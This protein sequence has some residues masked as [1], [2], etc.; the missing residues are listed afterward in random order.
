MNIRHSRCGSL[1]RRLQWWRLALSGV[2]APPPRRWRSG[3]W[4]TLSGQQAAGA[5]V[6]DAAVGRRS[7]Q[8]T[9]P[10][11]PS[12]GLPAT[13]QAELARYQSTSTASACRPH[14]TQSP[15]HI[16]LNAQRLTRFSPTARQPRSPPAAVS[17][18]CLAKQYSPAAGSRSTMRS[19]VRH[20]ASPPSLLTAAAPAASPA[21]ATTGPVSGSPFSLSTRLFNRAAHR[22]ASLLQRPFGSATA[23]QQPQQQPRQPATASTASLPATDAYAPTPPTF[24][25]TDSGLWIDKSECTSQAPLYAPSLATVGSLG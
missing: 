18:V 23:R 13:I 11:T 10:C 19:P 21:F 24:V 3:E 8:T 4:S 1:V 2:V 17:L 7:S 9:A 15:L 16:Q 6:S 25:H 12:I 14:T 5:D 22:P 20:A